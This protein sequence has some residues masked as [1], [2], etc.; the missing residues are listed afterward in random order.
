MTT[1]EETHHEEPLHLLC[2]ITHCMFRDPVRVKHSGRTYER[3]AILEHWNRKGKPHDPLTNIVL[4]S[5]EIEVDWQ[6]RDEIALFL[7]ERPDF[8]PD[9]WDIRELLPADVEGQ[10][11]EPGIRRWI[12]WLMF[13]DFFQAFTWLHLAQIALACACLD[14]SFW[15][16]LAAVFSLFVGERTGD[17]SRAIAV[18]RDYPGLPWAQGYACYLV[19]VYADGSLNQSAHVANVGGIEGVM[20][21]LLLHKSS[22]YVQVRALSALA[23]LAS[24]SENVAAITTKG[25]LELILDSM[26]RYTKHVEVQHAACM[27]CKHLAEGSNRTKLDLA[28]GGLLEYVTLALQLMPYDPSVQFACCWSLESL[29]KNSSAEVQAATVKHRS[30]DLLVTALQ[31]YKHNHGIQAIALS[32]LV[33]LSSGNATRSISIFEMGAVEIALHDMATFRG[34]LDA[35]GPACSLIAN[36]LRSGG[37]QRKKMGAAIVSAGGISAIYLAL[38]DHRTNLWLRADA[39]MI[40]ATLSAMGSEVTKKVLAVLGLQRGVEQHLP[41]SQQMYSKCMKLPY[42]MKP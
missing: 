30:V 27:I 42:T 13:R 3:W 26:Q 28:T 31:R 29:L 33:H 23:N 20:D 32:A 6:K 39:C 34:S 17:I 22:S 5:G 21:A 16:G 12:V 14:P 9:G 4:Q 37:S 25:G 11:E 10:W 15:S 2:P 41:G 1:L 40:L 35:Q 24:S 36:L 8:A 38:Q 18:L 7:K 19:A